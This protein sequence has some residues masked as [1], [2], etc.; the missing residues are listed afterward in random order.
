[1]DGFL[2]HEQAEGRRVRDDGTGVYA[3]W[4]EQQVDD[5][6]TARAKKREQRTKQKYAKAAADGLIGMS[7]ER[8]VGRSWAAAGLRMNAK[9]VETPAT[10]EG[11]ATSG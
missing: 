2:R 4:L 10:A 1:M 8:R 6:A 3:P 7:I 9:V 5:A 11:T